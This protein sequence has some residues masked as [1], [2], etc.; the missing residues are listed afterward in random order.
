MY[1]IHDTATQR[2]VAYI[3]TTWFVIDV[4][5]LLIVKCRCRKPVVARNDLVLSAF[6]SDSLITT[7]LS[8][9]PSL[10][11]IGY[12]FQ[13]ICIVVDRVVCFPADTKLCR[14]RIVF[15]FIPRDIEHVV[16]TVDSGFVDGW[17]QTNEPSPDIWRSCVEFDWRGRITRWRRHRSRWERHES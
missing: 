11:F 16:L 8:V 14:L 5:F 12:K 4:P 3:R 1:Y 17:F 10:N 15:L 13:P 6:P 2:D 7:A 9:K